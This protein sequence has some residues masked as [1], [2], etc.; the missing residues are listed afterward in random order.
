MTVIPSPDDTLTIALSLARFGWHVFP[1]EIAETDG[2]RDKRPLIKW[3]KGAT[4]DA[5]TIATWWTG[6]FVTAW[7][8]VNCEKSGIIVADLDHDHG[9]N[10]LGNLI[11]AGH[12]LPETLSYQT[13]RGGE[14]WVYKAPPGRWTIGKGAPVKDVDI[15]AGNGLFVYY[16]PELAKKPKLATAP[17]WALLPY[18][19]TKSS[20]GAQVDEWLSVVKPG[21][22]GAKMREQVRRIKHHGTDHETLLDAVAQVVKL[23]TV[24]SKRGAPEAIDR[25]REEYTRY[26]PEYVRHFDAALAG[27]VDHWGLPR[28]LVTIAKPKDDYLETQLASM[29]PDE[30]DDP[31]PDDPSEDDEDFEE[32]V[33]SRVHLLKVDVEARRRVAAANYIGT[34]VLSW[35]DLEAREVRW[36]VEDLVAEGSLTYLVARA[37]TGKT[38]TFIDMACRIVTGSAWLGKRVKPCSILIV[39]GEGVHGAIDRFR[40]WCEYNGVELAA[41]KPYIRFVAGANINNDESLSKLQEQGVGCELIIID[42]YATTS[43]IEKEDDA[44]LASLTL[45]RARSINPDAALMFTHHPRKMDEDGDRPVMRGSGAMAGAADTVITL[46]RDRSYIGDGVG[47]EDWLALS[48]EADHAGKNRNAQTETFRGLYIKEID[49]SAVLVQ[50]DAAALSKADSK[51]KAFLTGPMTVVEFMAASKLSRPTALKYLKESKFASVKKG[52]GPVADVY[53]PTSNVLYLM[54]KKKPAADDEQEAETS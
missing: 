39:L 44:A 7:I 16:G 20:T 36:I 50:V 48:T 45:N 35:S 19:A 12:T 28:E 53:S 23:A 26:F 40:A 41:I 21:T 1:V 37:N 29:R 25:M 51:V 15:R 14:H 18:E 11:D 8:G 6:K 3:L 49:G 43:G 52:G 34:D 30:I 46:F 4:T 17:E 10:G 47:D 42:T 54:A 38:F 24:E 31:E 2:R 22:P 27:S 33:A 5:E 32:D 13:G 9:K